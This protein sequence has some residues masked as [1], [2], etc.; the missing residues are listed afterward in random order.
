MAAVVKRLWLN[1]LRVLLLAQLLKSMIKNLENDKTN[2][3]LILYSDAAVGV[4][5]IHS[6]MNEIIQY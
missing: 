4:Y 6:R 5:T 1:H 2:F 3:D